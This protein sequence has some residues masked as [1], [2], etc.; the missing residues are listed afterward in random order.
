VGVC[1]QWGRHHLRT[2]WGMTSNDPCLR[3]DCGANTYAR[4]LCENCYQAARR[5]VA[6]KHTTWEIL[7]RQGKAR[8]TG[9]NAAKNWLLTPSK[10]KE[11]RRENPWNAK[12][13]AD[14]TLT[15]AATR[16]ATTV[17]HP[18]L[19]QLAAVASGV[20][21]GMTQKDHTK[22]ETAAF[23][24]VHHWEIRNYVS[25]LKHHGSAYRAQVCAAFVKASLFFGREAVE[26]LAV[27]WKDLLWTSVGDPIRALYLRLNAADEDNARHKL[28]NDQ[29]YALTVAAIRAALS[30]KEI[31]KVQE[32]AQDFGDSDLDERI[33]R[34]LEKDR[35]RQA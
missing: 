16:A 34:S 9:R 4:G 21:G 10:K 5:L 15:S 2:G 3:P 30:G 8:A 20:L 14:P 29:R 18:Q 27:R 19:Q 24:D 25:L 28:G 31:S 1:V 32:T 13:A 7:E 26:P 6:Q 12:H 17:L 35:R 33:L 11:K 23:V 22:A